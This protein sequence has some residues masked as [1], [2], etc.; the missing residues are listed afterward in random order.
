M[1]GRLALAFACFA[2]VMTAIGGG[3]RINALADVARTHELEGLTTNARLIARLVEDLRTDNLPVSA[4]RLAAYVPEGSKLT[5]SRSGTPPVSVSAAGFEA[6]APD[7]PLGVRETLGSTTI[8]LVQ[9]AS[10]LREAVRQTL[11][12][13]LA[14]LVALVLVAGLVGFVVATVLARPFNRLAESAAALGRGRFD[15]ERPRSRI[16]EVVSIATSLETSAIQLEQSLRRDREFFHH[17]SHILRTP[18]TGLRLELE[19]LSLREDVND[20]VHRSAVRSLADAARL[21][22]TVTELLEFAR[23]R[24]L[25]AGAEISL[26]TLGSEVAQRW[27]DQ[28]PESREVRAYVDGGPE[29]TLTPGP[30][31]QLLDSV[32]RD[33]AEHGTGTVTLRFAGQEDLVKVTVCSGPG[34]RGAELRAG[35]QTAHTIAEVLG[36]RCTG[37]ATSGELEILL[38]RR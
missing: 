36:G 26:L 29:F 10:V 8:T 22:V 5:I 9:D 23:A 3:I 33:V 16:P 28:L 25:V 38:P 17:A 4:E 19:E 20:D 1:R 31:E 15:F 32:L 11:T 30:V 13:L 18:L 21:E 6:E 35:A 7:E 2:L 14:L 27:R 37:D 34:R 24:R 12:P